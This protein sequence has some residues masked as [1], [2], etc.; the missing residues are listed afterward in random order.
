ME[1]K[2]VLSYLGVDEVKTIDE[3]KNAFEA[4]HV[5]ISAIKD[6]RETNPKLKQVFDGV[7]APLLG[8]AEN[9]L[10]GILKENGI[11]FEQGELK[12]KGFEDIAELAKEKLKTKFAEYESKVGQGGDAALK[13]MQE[14]Y[15]KIEKEYNNTKEL[16]GTTKNE[17]EQHKLSADA[18]LKNFKIE[19]ADKNAFGKLKLKEGVKEIELVGFKTLFN[20]SYQ[21]DFDEQ[22]NLIIKDKQGNL[23]PSKA[24]SGT[25]KTIEEIY[26]E[27]AIKAGIVDVNGNGGKP[28]KPTNQQQ[29]SQSQEPQKKTIGTFIHPNA[30]R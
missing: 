27:E 5:K 7:T 20:Q 29:Q 4:D 9:K 14:K 18:T 25:F 12:D 26:Q 24:K 23:I 16:L 17:F 1:L 11:V 13:E 2:D 8:K 15:S 21:R 6:L 19:I 10:K 28:V 22:G 30:M 3:F